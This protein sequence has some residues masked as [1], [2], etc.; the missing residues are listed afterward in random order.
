M[1]RSSH[2]RGCL[3]G[4]ANTLK[5]LPGWEGTKKYQEMSQEEANAI[6]WYYP[7]EYKDYLNSTESGS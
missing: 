1:F 2:Q 4:G 7:P 3:Q 5:I 6:F